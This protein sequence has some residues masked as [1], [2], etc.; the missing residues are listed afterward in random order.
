MAKVLHADAL[1]FP[2]GG[3]TGTGVRSSSSLTGGSSARKSKKAEYRA[4]QDIDE[5]DENSL[6]ALFAEGSELEHDLSMQYA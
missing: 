4:D 3:N 5:R 1:L 6:E 2:M